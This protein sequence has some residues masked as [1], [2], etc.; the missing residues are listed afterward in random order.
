MKK[1]KVQGNFI[2]ILN[3]DNTEFS[4]HPLKDS[5][6]QIYDELTANPL[7]KLFGIESDFNSK[8]NEI[9]SFRFDEVQDELG[10]PFATID[11][12]VTFLSDNLAFSLGGVNGA[13][14]SV[15][16][17]EDQNATNTA[18]SLSAGVYEPLDNNGLGPFTNTVHLPNG[19]DSPIWNTTTNQFDFSKL[20]LGSFIVLRLD[21]DLTTTI[22]NTDLE[23]D[24][25]F[26]IGDSGAYSVV[27]ARRFFKNNRTYSSETLTMMFYIGDT[28]TKLNPAK[29]KVKTDSNSTLKLNGWSMGITVK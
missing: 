8:S 22:G 7:I 12:L 26:A 25:D 20:A 29:L 14:G 5:R 11:D 15:S 19:V 13:R 23:I 4:R 28:P 21:F 1:L 2:V 17:I 9:D 6:F 3:D 10:T 24:M 27:L 18:I 16:G